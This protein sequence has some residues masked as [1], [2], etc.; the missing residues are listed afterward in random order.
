MASVRMRGWFAPQ[1]AAQVN[2][3]PDGYYLTA[4]TK[5]LPKVNGEPIQRRTLL[6]DGD[7]IELRGLVLEFVDRD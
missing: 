2:K 5:R 3:R 7:K 1:L 6:K 4:T